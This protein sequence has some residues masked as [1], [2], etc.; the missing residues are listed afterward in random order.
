[1]ERLDLAFDESALMR[2]VFVAL[3]ADDIDSD[4]GVDMYRICRNHYLQQLEI[5]A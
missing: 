2:G 1:M 3:G 4:A 5:E